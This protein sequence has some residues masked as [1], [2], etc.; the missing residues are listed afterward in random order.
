MT[1][2]RSF[3]FSKSNAPQTALILQMSSTRD[4]AETARRMP[5]EWCKIIR[6]ACQPGNAAIWI[7]G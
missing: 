7:L 5:C 4:G 6:L 3:G 1:V 2:L